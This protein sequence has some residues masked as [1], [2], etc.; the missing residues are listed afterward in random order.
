MTG[1]VLLAGGT[2]R[3]MGRETPKQMLLIGGKPILLHVLEKVEQIPEI[4]KVV[5]TCP[6]DYIDYIRTL[7]VNR[8]LTDK[9]ICVNGGATR[10]ESVYL[11]LLQ[12]GDCEQV[13]LHEAVR[14][15]VTIAEYQTLINCKAACAFYGLPIPFTVL[16]G[17][18]YVEGILPRNELINVQLP[19]KFPTARLLMVHEQ[20]RREGRQFTEDAGMYY[21]YTGEKVRV[22]PG[23]EYNIKITYPMDLVLGE[24]IYKE[25]ILGRTEQ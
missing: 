21:A 13:I 14:P 17:G 2:G 10:Q 15:F 25:R 22:L 9:Y 5:I 6:P 11:G 1:M 20:A 19:Q 7:L 18:E 4:S 24:V 12:L 3:R 16:K 23:S 8:H